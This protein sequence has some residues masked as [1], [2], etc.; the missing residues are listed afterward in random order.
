M[1]VYNEWLTPDKRLAHSGELGY[2]QRFFP[3]TP[4]VIA[5][6]KKIKDVGR[7][8]A[9]YLLSDPGAVPNIKLAAKAAIKGMVLQDNRQFIKNIKRFVIHV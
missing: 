7:K 1:P 4:Q 2:G 5:R 8:S 3:F 6:I 9:I